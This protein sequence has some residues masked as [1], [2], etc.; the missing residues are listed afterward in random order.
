MC[1]SSSTQL[2]RCLAVHREVEV[3]YRFRVQLMTHVVMRMLDMEGMPLH[4]ARS[5]EAGRESKGGLGLGGLV[6]V[7]VHD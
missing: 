2:T 5:R 4:Q 3:V 6:T 1:H 7:W